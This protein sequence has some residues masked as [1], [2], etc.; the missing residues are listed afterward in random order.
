MISPSRV[1]VSRTTRAVT[2][3]AIFAGHQGGGDDDAHDLAVLGGLPVGP[4][5]SRFQREPSVGHIRGEVAGVQLDRFIRLRQRRRRWPARGLTGGRVGGFRGLVLR[6]AAHDQSE[7]AGG[8]YADDGTHEIALGSVVVR[9]GVVSGALALGTNDMEALIELHVDLGAV[10]EGDFDLVLA[11]LV[12]D[13][14]VGD[15]PPAGLLERG[16]LGLLEL[17]GGDRTVPRVVVT[18]GEGGGATTVP[19][20]TRAAP[21]KIR[22]MRL[23]VRVGFIASR[24]DAR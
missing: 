19:A 21:A 4:T 17:R 3:L 12:V 10:V 13:L 8:K 5:G 18:A 20:V 2:P 1:T 15:G 14:G 22:A 23:R 24:Y 9:T 11:L 16:L 7:A 6:A